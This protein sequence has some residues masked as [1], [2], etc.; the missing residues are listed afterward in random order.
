MKS[1]LLVFPTYVM[2]IAVTG[3]N[4]LVG[5][6][7]VLRALRT[8]HTVIG[9]DKAAKEDTK[10]RHDPQFTFVLADLANFEEA[11]KAFEGCDAIVQLAGVNQ[12]IDYKVNTHN[13]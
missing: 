3:C 6:P 12:P 9:I 1:I 10:F 7:V 11:L 13:W 4:G 2:K 5:Q 8:G